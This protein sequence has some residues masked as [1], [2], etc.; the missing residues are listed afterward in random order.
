MKQFQMLDDDYT[1]ELPMTSSLEAVLGANWMIMP[2]AL[3][4][5]M[6]IASRTGLD[7]RGAV[8]IANQRAEQRHT[9]QMGSG[10]MHVKGT[11]NVYAQEGVAVIPIF[12]SLFRRGNYFSEA[13]GSMSMELI[14]SDAKTALTSKGVKAA[15]LDIDSPGGSV[16]FTEE[17]A[18][19]ITELEAETGKTIHTFSSGMMTSAAQWIGSATSRRY[20]T[21]NAMAGSVGVISTYVSRAEAE[22]KAGYKR[23]QIVSSVS[24][25]KAADP[26][27]K[28]GRAQIQEM[29]DQ[30]GENFVAQ[31]VI[32]LGIPREQIL[33]WKGGVKIGEAAVKAGMADGLATRRQV[34]EGLASG[35]FPALQVPVALDLSPSLATAEEAVEEAEV[36]PVEDS[37]GAEEV[38]A[39][40]AS[41]SDDVEKVETETPSDTINSETEGG[42]QMEAEN[43]DVVVSAEDRTTFQN[44]AAKM[45]FEIKPK[46]KPAAAP[47][48][49]AAP[50]LSAR[51][52]KLMGQA[53][54]GFLAKYAGKF[55]GET[56]DAIGA[57]YSKAQEFG[58][59][60]L[61][62][63]Y[64]EKAPSL[65]FNTDVL[66]PA[67]AGHG[68]R[69]AEEPE[70]A[71]GEEDALTKSCREA[72]EEMAASYE[73][74]QS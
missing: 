70:G 17:L 68:Y 57:L 69:I 33:S 8:E 20:I 7:I 30:M 49:G 22:A 21:R 4:N 34:M 56:R 65:K 74:E 27:T 36:A 45:G 15:M 38:P 19:T 10:A 9:M 28:D 62:E 16:N 55:T 46:A 51:E 29:V 31:M 59:E 24:P 47:A 1:I 35:D 73:N 37:I 52:I 64:A 2:G 42:S 61:V 12:D 71:E 60:G 41:E 63:A 48:A 58:F 11:R 18:N 50:A 54:D 40:E 66:P 53:K 25:N 72:A 43:E 26:N 3:M 32:N 5:I 23:I 44:L 67:G 14:E 39:V 13:S 6:Q